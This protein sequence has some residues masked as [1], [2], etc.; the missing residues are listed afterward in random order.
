MV[1]YNCSSP[2]IL[3]NDE[4]YI[5]FLPIFLISLSPFK[6]QWQTIHKTNRTLHASLTLHTYLAKSF[7]SNIIIE[8]SYNLNKYIQYKQV[9]NLF[10]KVSL[11]LHDVIV[12]YRLDG[13]KKLLEFFAY[14]F[15]LVSKATLP[16]YQLVVKCA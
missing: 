12:L 2:K 6:M 11:H 4:N 5:H 10:E 8:I 1:Y 15:H 3:V 9:W 14:Y 7:V 16:F 13:K